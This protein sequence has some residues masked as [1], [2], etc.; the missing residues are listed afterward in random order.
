MM[1]I[2]EKYDSDNGVSIRID[3]VVD[4]GSLQSLKEVMQ[5]NLK[6]KMQITLN[7]SGLIHVDHAG[8]VFLKRHRNKVKFEEIS[9]FLKMEIGLKEY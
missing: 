7:L 8:K 2:E 9:E 4:S 5:F 6:K 1:R 3:G